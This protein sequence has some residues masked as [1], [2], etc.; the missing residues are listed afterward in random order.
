ME[1]ENNTPENL[2]SDLIKVNSE[3]IELYEKAA[4]ETTDPELKILFTK[5]ANDSRKFKDELLTEVDTEKNIAHG[6]NV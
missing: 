1:T 4:R 2:M 6:D 3:R 5:I